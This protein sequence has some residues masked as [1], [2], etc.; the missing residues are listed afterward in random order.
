MDTFT[1]ET[2]KYVMGKSG[3]EIGDK[4][5]AK[6]LYGR[7]YDMFKQIGDSGIKMKERGSLKLPK[8]SYEPGK[9]TGP[10]YLYERGK[11][12]KLILI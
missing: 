10:Q 11:L 6:R 2:I 7:S 12:P 1:R 9:F 8:F 5:I 3:E 4:V